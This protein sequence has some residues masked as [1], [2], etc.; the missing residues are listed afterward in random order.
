MKFQNKF[1]LYLRWGILAL[2]LGSITYTAYQHQILGGDKAASIHAICPFGGLESLYMFFATGSFISKIYSGTMILFFITFIVA[3]IF[4]RSFCGLICPFGTIQEFFAKIGRLIFKKNYKI[5]INIDNYLRYFKYVILIL[6]VF[7]AWYTAGLWMAPYDPW[8]VYAHLS[9]GFTAIWTE[10]PIGFIILII[11]V[12]GS[13]IYDRFFCKYLC[14]MGAF[15]GI[16]GKISPFKV[17]RNK[18]ICIA[19]GKCS[20]VCPVNIDVANEDNVKSAEC[21]NCQI[22]I[23]NCPKEGALENRFGEK[24]INTLLSIILVLA[25]FFVPIWI[26]K[27]RDELQTTQT[28]PEAGEKINIED[29]RGFMSIKDASTFLGISI[30]SFYKLFEIPENIPETTKLKEVS[31]LVEG[32]SFDSI[33]H[34]IEESIKKE[35]GEVIEEIIYSPYKGQVDTKLIKGS[36]SIREASF[37]LKVNIDEFYTIFEI[38]ENVSDLTKLNEISTLVPEYDFDRIKISL[39]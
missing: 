36:M 1:A 34:Q 27:S 37:V 4:R 16:L 29:L 13:I 33:K 19:C 7:Y 6:T 35:N 15:Y 21:I 9:E 10:S 17:F 23:L 5:N 25:L 32:Y 14:P 39:D 20:E 18:N 3:I 30:D 24:G 12:I 28:L 11:T 38:P 2:I 8:S 31:D 26:L 22:C